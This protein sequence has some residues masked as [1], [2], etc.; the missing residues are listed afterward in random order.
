MVLFVPKNEPL[1]RPFYKI[2][3]GDDAELQEQ[4]VKKTVDFFDSLGSFEA[5]MTKA[6]KYGL[7]IG[8]AFSIYDIK[9]V[10][11]ITDR[12]IQI[13]RAAF[14]TIPAVAAAT[15]WMA[16]LEISKKYVSKDKQQRA[17]FMAA[18]AP[19]AVYCVW[20]KRLASFPKVFAGPALIGAAYR[21]SVDDNLFFGWDQSW[22]NPNDPKDFYRKRMSIFGE[23]KTPEF[24][25]FSDHRPGLWSVKDPGPAYAKFEDK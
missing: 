23:A 5:R 7:G 2:Y 4:P 22:Q 15:S 17:Y 13:A 9:A 1:I 12:R 6:V 16:V 14:F 10:S 21:K 19:A 8:L 18:A 25:R 11:M 3:R 24:L 20:R